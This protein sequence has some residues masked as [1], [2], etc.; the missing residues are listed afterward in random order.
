MSGK[1]CKNCVYWYHEPETCHPGYGECRIRAPMNLGYGMGW[2]LLKG[3]KWCG[4]FKKKE[5]SD[6]PSA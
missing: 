5:V 1:A 2:P 4:E 3:H 6:E